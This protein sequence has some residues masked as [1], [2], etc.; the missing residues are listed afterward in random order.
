[1]A[2]ENGKEEGGLRMEFCTIASGSSGNCAYIGTKYTNILIDAGM[3]GKR[4]TEGL[5]ALGLQGK[6][7]DALFITHEHLDHIKGAGIL[8]RRFDIPIYATADTWAA[9]EQ[10]LGKVAPSN[11]RIVYADEVCAINDL[12]VK[13]FRIPHDAA[14]PVG[15]TVFSG[16]KKVTLATDIGHVTDTVRENLVDS[17]LLL[18]EANH[19]VDML[20]KGGYPWALKQRI[21]GENGHLSNHTAG[22]LLAE[23]MT[24]RLKYVFLGHLSEENN[25][26]HLAYE[27]VEGILRKNRIAVGAQVKMDMAS[28]CQNGVKVE[29]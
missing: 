15:Y 25:N 24:G 10:G 17:D 6:Q 1:M 29:L 4:I 18:L 22:E 28:R 7:I 14:E 21:L 16:G 12:C 27:T 23:V 2:A 13:P 19:D 11:K 5:E 20:K 8:S 9:M 3:S 26:P